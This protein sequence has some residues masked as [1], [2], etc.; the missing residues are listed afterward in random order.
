[1]NND[2]SRAAEF[3]NFLSA[4]VQAWKELENPRPGDALVCDLLGLVARQAGG[5][6]QAG[7][8]SVLVI[9][10]AGRSVLLVIMTFAVIKVVFVCFWFQRFCQ[11][12]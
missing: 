4:A 1:M 6:C 5:S 3:L 11:F 9:L 8:L 12:V 2:S 10:A 7:L